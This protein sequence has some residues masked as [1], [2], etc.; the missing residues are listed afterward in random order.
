MRVV[1]RHHYF[2]S[3]ARSCRAHDS[4]GGSPPHNYICLL[5]PVV[6]CISRTIERRQRYLKRPGDEP[7]SRNN[8]TSSWCNRNY[9]AQRGSSTGSISSS[10]Y[11]APPT[12]PSPPPPPP[13]RAVSFT[14]DN[15]GSTRPHHRPQRSAASTGSANGKSSSSSSRGQLLLELYLFALTNVKPAPRSSSAR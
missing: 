15:G 14:D 4:F 7:P 12:A 8:S 1:A 11:R 2:I 13:Q 5:Q 3:L 9:L 10:T 6:R